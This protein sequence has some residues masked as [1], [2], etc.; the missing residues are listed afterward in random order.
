MLP[1]T[2]PTPVREF[3]F[4]RYLTALFNMCPHW[5][6]GITPDRESVIAQSPTGLKYLVQVCGHGPVDSSAIRSVLMATAQ[7]GAQKSIL[8]AK[9]VAYAS[10][11]LELARLNGILLWT[12]DEVDY[13]VMAGSMESNAPLEHMGLEVRLLDVLSEHT[14]PDTRLTQGF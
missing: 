5:L 8:I 4:M 13:L 7:H 3:G 9:D 2:A 6:A 1:A 14:H 12:L 10:S 11:A